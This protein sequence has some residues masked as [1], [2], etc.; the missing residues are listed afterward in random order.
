MNW[1]DY[2]CPACN[3]LLFLPHPPI[4][5]CPDCR[6]EFYEYLAKKLMPEWNNTQMHDFEEVWI[7]LQRVWC[8]PIMK[9]W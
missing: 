1:F 2:P 6:A 3:C 4:R 7:V 9:E 5:A 8:W